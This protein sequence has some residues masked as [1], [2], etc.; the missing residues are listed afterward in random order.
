[1]HL[2]RLSRVRCAA[3]HGRPGA[4]RG[5]G[6]GA[7]AHDDAGSGGGLATLR[8]VLPG[9]DLGPAGHGEVPRSSL[10]ALVRVDLRAEAIQLRLG[11]P[12]EDAEVLLERGGAIRRGRAGRRAA[13]GGARRLPR[14]PIRRAAHHRGTRARARSSLRAEIV[15][16]GERVSVDARE[17]R[18][19]AAHV[20]APRDAATRSRR[21]R[22]E[23][24]K[25]RE[26]ARRAKNASRRRC[27]REGAVDRA[28]ARMR[29]DGARRPPPSRAQT[30][31]DD[32]HDPRERR[33]GVD[34]RDLPRSEPCARAAVDGRGAEKSQGA[35]G[36]VKF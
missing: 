23:T 13:G 7:R 12:G 4:L 32:L 28:N 20:E 16:G 9:G 31:R 36:G 34:A 27:P 30:I 33:R 3:V 19:G 5:G 26:S 25:A 14:D 35:S 6:G 24:A 11:E 10:H 18:E 22:D 15:E 1:M 8:H 2:G 21:D 29:G 17:R